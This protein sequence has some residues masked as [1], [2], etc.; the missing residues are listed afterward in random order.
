MNKR[1]LILIAFCLLNFQNIFSQFCGN[2]ASTADMERL[3]SN[4]A[5]FNAFGITKSNAKIYIPVTFHIVTNSEGDGGIEEDKVL[6]QL[7]S[8]NDD[9]NPHD[10]YFYMKDLKFNY[11]KSTI[12]FTNPIS[13]SA[14]SK[15]IGEKNTNGKNSVN[16]FI[17]ESAD[18]GGL[19]TT[20]G[21]YDPSLDVVVVRKAN[22]N[23]FDGTLAHELGH[24]FSLLHTFNGWD[25]VAFDPSV[26]GIPVSSQFSPGGVQNERVNGV[27]CENSGDFLCDTP[28]DYNLGFN[29]SGCSNYTGGCQDFVGALLDPQEVNFMGYF[30]GC[31]EYLFSNNQI[32]MV[33]TDFNSPQRNFLK[34]AYI[35]NLNKVENTNLL[36]PEND[37]ELA[38]FDNIVLNWEEVPNAAGYYVKLSQGVNSTIYKVEGANFL[39]L[40]NLEKNK[41]YRWQVIPI[42]EIGSCS[43]FTNAFKFTT[44]DLVKTENFK[45]E[46]LDVYPT[47]LNSHQTL[48]IK[49]SEPKNLMGNIYDLN[50]NNMFSFKLENSSK[51]EISL[52]DKLSAGIYFLRLSTSD[53]FQLIKLVVQ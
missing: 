50:G 25:Q 1:V 7:C 33:I 40:N 39:L 37:S 5:E 4:K 45:I 41:T 22:I 11:I 23:G 17:C 20:L 53:S 30:I 9:Y 6:Q 28:A 49:T 46:G 51:N 48:N 35:P 21:Y 27:N 12:L 47:V 18:T 44:G 14:G 42:G 15:M 36:L 13:Q 2:V 43:S 32:E 52:A 24:F 16:V 3:L 19:G 29:W 26:H 34:S 8:L 38:T 31:S 10:I